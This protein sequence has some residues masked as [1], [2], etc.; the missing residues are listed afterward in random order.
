[1]AGVVHTDAAAIFG[2]SLVNE[3]ED[4]I[5]FI[6]YRPVGVYDSKSPVT[7]TIPGN[8]SQYVSLRDSYFLI[9]CHIEET[10]SAGK[11]K[12]AAP[13]SERP[14]DI[15]TY[16]EIL[17]LQQEAERRYAKYE[18]AKKAHDDYTGTVESERQELSQTAES[19]QD[20]AVRAMK[21][22]IGEKHKHRS[23]EGLDGCIIPIDNV[24]HSM[25]NGVDV[26][27]NHKVV[28]TT[29]Q[30]YMYKAYI[31][32]LLNNS[33]STKRYQLES[34]GFFGDSGNKDTDFNISYNK[35]MEKR[36]RAFQDGNKVLLMGYLLSDIM[37]IQASIV[38]GVEISITLHP[39]TDAVRV[40]CL[41][42]KEYGALVIDDISMMVCKRQFSKEVILAHSD[43][44]ETSPAS[45]PFK[46]SET[47]A[48]NGHRGQSQVTIANPYESHIPTR[49]IV[50]MI[51]A[52]AHMGN[53]KLTPLNFQHFDI[54]D[55][56]FKID[57]ESVA[58]PPFQID[59]K[60]NKV[61][62]P[63]M[64]LYSIM[65]K[66][67]EDRDIGITV[68]EF[69]DGTFMLPFDVT[70]T[71]SANMEYLAKKEGGNCTLELQFDNPLKKDI[72]IL[73]YAIFPAEL[74]ID[75]ARN[76]WVEKI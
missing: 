21:G 32:T 29:N 35:G 37:G 15:K 20:F 25:W 55:A 75:G 26:T 66:I 9:Q 24:F 19:L 67:G 54:R 1:M 49:L 71:S 59:V 44:M 50:A 13:K 45:Y 7:F 28:S 47:R 3:A 8:S 33:A 68:D 43:V 64:E 52:S 18:E 14:A 31:E 46:E 38:N 70:P 6:P 74:K 16:E 60:N 2:G 4:D 10:D 40:H 69:K 62:Q 17:E 61:I 36:F 51:D 41:G 53:F 56:A 57:N 27:M 22:Y 34:H 65:G 58:K 48:Y 76:C 39:N 11:Y 63:L 42:N 12:Q 5:K 30:K 23:F 72:I 73:T